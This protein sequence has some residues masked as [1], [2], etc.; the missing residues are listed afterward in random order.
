[1]TVDCRSLISPKSLARTTFLYPYFFDYG[2]CLL[3]DYLSMFTSTMRVAKTCVVSS[4]NTGIKT[5]KLLIHDGCETLCF[6]QTDIDKP[7]LSS[8]ITV[9]NTN[10][11]IRVYLSHD[12][13]CKFVPSV[14]FIEPALTLHKV[15]EAYMH[16][17]FVASPVDVKT[18]LDV[19]LQFPRY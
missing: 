18:I 19:G 9:V 17:D 11:W 8:A 13:G 10:F 15:A 6:G 12:L 2:M 4:L 5:G 16:G 7:H 3:L 1:M 14:I